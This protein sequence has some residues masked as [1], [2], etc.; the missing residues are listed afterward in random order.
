MG[1]NFSTTRQSHQNTFFPSLNVPPVL[2]T[3]SSRHTCTITSGTVAKTLPS[4]VGL[5]AGRHPNVVGQVLAG[6]ALSVH[7]E[8]RQV[9]EPVE[10]VLLHQAVES[11]DELL[12]AALA[13]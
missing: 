7:A 12:V 13:E 1:V 3:G 6:P 11:V 4:S 9:G 2:I 8:V 5:V 10:V